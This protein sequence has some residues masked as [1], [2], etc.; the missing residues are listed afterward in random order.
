MTQKCVTYKRLAEGD[1]KSCQGLC[2]CLS[3]E[4]CCSMLDPIR[5]LRGRPSEKVL[6]KRKREWAHL[7][8]GSGKCDFSEWT[9][10]HTHIHNSQISVGPWQ[11]QSRTHTH[12]TPH[13]SAS[14]PENVCVCVC[15]CPTLLASRSQLLHHHHHHSF[16]P[17]PPPLP[18]RS[19]FIATKSTTLV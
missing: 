5:D 8:I 14:T 17:L 6:T 16:R 12:T 1:F 2:V 15:V 3:K 9:D 4:K 11:W 10:T 13:Y 18:F 19:P 7:P